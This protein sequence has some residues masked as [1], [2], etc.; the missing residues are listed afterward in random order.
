MNVMQRFTSGEKSEYNC[1]RGNQLIARWL[2]AALHGV[3]LVG[4]LYAFVKPP[5]RHVAY[6]PIRKNSRCG[7]AMTTADFHV[8]TVSRPSWLVPRG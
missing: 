6:T 5:S 2:L 4:W 1:P 7:R 8:T 3:G